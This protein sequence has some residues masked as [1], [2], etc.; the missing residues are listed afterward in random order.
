M[1]RLKVDVIVT[2]TAQGVRAAQGATATIP[3]VVATVA[4]AV[5]AGL[6]SSL[7]H[8]GGNVTGL[9]FF[10]PELMAKRLEL[11]GE[12][13]PANAEVAILLNPDN[14]ANAPILRTMEL[15]ANVLKVG[16]QPFEVRR[17]GEFESTFAAIADKHIGAVVIQD[18]PVLITNAK[19][20]ADLA[21][22]RQ[23]VTCGF[24]EFAAAGGLL[25]YGVN[26]SDMFRRAATFVDKVLRGAK[27]A[28]IP[29]EQPT[30]F[31]LIVN[32]KTAKALGLNIP[33]TLL[34]RA[35]ELIE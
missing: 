10:D 11:L 22:R 9:T 33:P 6:I 23:L 35:D 26:F 29:V 17:P 16:M 12:V 24:S 25:A 4:D 1:V 3:I 8:P 15:T 20:I 32:L 28:D 5:A 13:A 31:Q 7:S 27:P 2:H 30:K 19:A 18:D 34:A 21:L 14:P